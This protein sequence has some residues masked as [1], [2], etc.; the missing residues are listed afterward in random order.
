MRQSSA[1]DTAVPFGPSI[2]GRS[3]SGG[4][5]VRPDVPAKHHLLTVVMEDYYN[6]SPL[7]SVIGPDHWSRFESRL[8][9]GTRETL[10]LLDEFGI[11]ATFFVLGWVA[12]LMPELVREVAEHGHEI[13]SKGYF[14]RNIRQMAAGAFRDDLARARE[15]L[16]R[17]VHRPVRGYRVAEGRF[18][19]NDLWA[20]NILAEEGYAYD[21]S[22]R[23]MFREYATEPWRRFAHEHHHAGKRLWE[24]PI[25]AMDL[26][27]YHVPIAGGNYF[28]QF[29]HVLVKRAVAHWDRTYTDPFVMYFHTWEL[30]PHQ[31][32]L[33]GVP[34][35]SRIRQY[36]NLDKM[37]GILRHYL[38]QYHFS[39][40]A[41]H[42][43]LD[44]GRLAVA[45]LRDSD[46]PARADT[47]LAAGRM[48]TESLPPTPPRR[49][50]GVVIPC[51]NEELI[52]PYLSNTLRTM[53]RKLGETYELQFIFVDDGS[54]DET[55][56]VLQQTFG[57]RPNCLA[58]RHSANQGVAAAIMTG[59]R[60]ARADVVC[61]I[62]C[63]CTYDPLELRSMIPLLRDGV[64]MVTASPYH[65]QGSVRNVPRW[66]LA[67]SRTASAMYRVVLRQKLATYTSCFRVYRRSTALSFRLERAGFLGVA[68]MVGRLDL[69]GGTVVEYPA[70]LEARLLGR[71][72]MKVVGTIFGHLG[73]LASLALARMRSTPAGAAAHHPGNVSPCDVSPPVN[74]GN[75]R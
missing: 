23:P 32:K 65:S 51:F 35:L 39:N 27:G 24:F 57:Q 71:S 5:A 70:L 61:S 69:S 42:L 63:D 58:I 38:G 52:L 18:G 33:N 15:A 1:E 9:I 6:V 41:A 14:H 25:P 17:A 43:G 22:I 59:I 7:K 10:A 46:S 11:Q 28:R 74:R 34:L 40:I 75:P 67:L 64:D 60:A 30:D 37:V 8:E 45:D 19:P 54:S 62:D 47:A 31:P 53:E 73:L 48:P 13:A 16:E 20:L 36:R 3:A 72:K 44:T 21:S 66:R 56:R 68:E 49:P 55:W 4:A 26:F 2:T 12:D 50:V 29:P